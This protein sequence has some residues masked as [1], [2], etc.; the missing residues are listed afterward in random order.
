MAKKERIRF[1]FARL[2]AERGESLGGRALGG[3]RL[4]RIGQLAGGNTLALV[5][6]SALGLA[7]LFQTIEKNKM[8]EPCSETKRD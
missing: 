3:S 7:S 5:V 2:V 1:A 8:L 4:L 6:G